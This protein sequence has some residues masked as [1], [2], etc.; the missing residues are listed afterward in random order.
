[1]DIIDSHRQT[2]VGLLSLFTCMCQNERYHHNSDPSVRT[3]L[4]ETRKN[5]ET[6]ELT[7]VS[8]HRS[9]II[10]IRA[11]ALSSAL[12]SLQPPAASTS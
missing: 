1:M 6:I 3:L 12:F 2:R 11:S 7:A 4:T 9:R 8:L 5:T 10:A